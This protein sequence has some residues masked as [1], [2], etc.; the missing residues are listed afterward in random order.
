MNRSKTIRGFTLVEIL[1]VVIIL[2]ILAAVALPKFTSVTAA[3][4]ASMLADDLRCFR[5]QMLVFKGQ[6]TN[7]SP[8]CATVGAEPTEALF[9]NHMTLASDESGA[10]AAQGTPGFR[11]GPYFSQM[12]QNPVNGKR[13]I[14]IVANGAAFPA[15][16]DDSHGW[17]YQA[18]TMT[19]KS[20]AVGAD[21]TG[22]AFIDY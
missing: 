10:T 21:D 15:A 22:K 7:L 3:A 9:L 20:D 4:R 14:E 6:H 11:Y 16:A 19:L 8:G 5:T 2:G 13:T 17:I 12:P 18:D 1:I